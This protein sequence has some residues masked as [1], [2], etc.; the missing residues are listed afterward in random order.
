[1]KSLFKKLIEVLCKTWVWSLLLVFLLA[2][3]IWSFGPL[4]AVSDNRFWEGT[5]A[6]LITISVLFLVWGL[7]M[8]FTNWR[9][10]LIK[11]QAEES[12]TGKECLRKSVVMEKERLELA[13]RFTDAQRVLKDSALFGE[14]GARGRKELPWYVLIGPQGSGKTSLLDF[15]GLDFPLDRPAR[16]LTRDTSSTGSC[17]WYFTHQAILLDTSGRYFDQ[18]D[19]Q[20]DG[21]AWMT[22]LGL[23][24]G[25]LRTQPLSGVLVTL[26]VDILLD[27]LDKRLEKVAGDVRVRLDEIFRRLHVDVPVYLVLTKADSIAG[28]DDFFDQLSREESEQV[29]GTTF[30][31][32]QRGTDVDV[33]SQAFE[34]LLQ[35]LGS[36]VITRIHQE[37]DSQRRGRMLEFPNQLGGIGRRLNIF[38]ELAFSGNRYQRASQLR[39]FYLTRAPHVMQ[40]GGQQP[41][42]E[43][44]AGLPVQHGGRARFIHDLLRHVIFPESDLA[45]LGKE[46]RKKIQW[47]QKGMY[48]AAL[49]FLAVS[50]ALW[51]T[52][53]NANHDRLEKLRTLGEQWTRQTSSLTAEDDLL[54]ILASLNTLYEAARV[55][56]DS[57]EVALY[58]RSGLYQGQPANEVLMRAYHAGLQT[59]L[60]PRMVSM[61]EARILDSLRDREQLLS[62]LRAYLM[63]IQREHRLPSALE[64]WATADWSIR[65]AGHAQAQRE[66]N[67]H[68]KRLLALPFVY[69]ANDALVAQAR[70]VLRN[71]SLATVVYRVLREK[72]RVLPDYSLAHHTGPQ[73]AVLAGADYRI[74]GLYTRQGYER[75]FVTHGTGLVTEIM[76]DNWVLGEGAPFSVTQLRALMVELEKLY[77]R[78]YADHWAEAIGRVSLHPFEG[79]AQGAVQMA[80]LA[81]AH[82]PLLR[83]LTE[84]RDNTR[85]PMLADSL[86]AAKTQVGKTVSTPAVL[87]QAVALG[88]QLQ[89]SAASSL[90]ETAKKSLQ[91]RFD[92]LHRLLDEESGPS[93]DLMAAL[94]A[95]NELQMQMAALARSG[96]PDL[97]A[98]E[99]AKG[100]MSGQRDAL[101]NLRSAATVLPQPVGGWFDKLAEDTWSFVL[102]QSHH[103]LNQRYKAE[104]YS[105]YEQ[106]LDKRYPFHA[107][108]S[109][110]VALEDFRE[111]FGPQGIAERFFDNYLRPFV[112]GSP[113]NLRLRTLDGYSLPMSRAYLHQMAGVHDIRK[114]FFSTHTPEPQVQFTLEP[115][116]LDPGVRRAEFR[117]GDQSLE[118]RHGPIVPMGFKWPAGIDNGRAS[119][120]MDGRLG[121]PLGIEKNNGPWSLFRLFDLMQTEPLQGRDVLLLKADVGGMRAHYLLSSLRAPN[122]FDMT[123][124]R[125]FRMPAQL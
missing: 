124:L 94:N 9:G 17:D 10:S 43:T 104:L 8:V 37:R 16:K 25:R 116:T 76:R 51:A 73:E 96:Q 53:F 107:H 91:R 24:Q 19:P 55:F 52:G 69:P 23:L 13:S 115:Y 42:P 120:V 93:A 80:G 61:F 123:A 21:G 119:L 75:Y 74:P 2:A 60:L 36:Q 14:L 40:Q 99:M 45:M 28:F 101:N 32:G 108:S 83:L 12:E 109:S 7:G 62:S 50:G 15:S 105:F 84:V 85:F 89:Q 72:A 92:A 38:A 70:Q 68:F 90:P 112:S 98:Y 113:G 63:L 20:V 121:R 57:D 26:P 87:D 22:L 65:Y 6:R 34:T 79:P 3:S 27:G 58:E 71:E 54:T 59:Q 100:R 41:E 44:G 102:Y 47:R 110:D 39:G 5:S 81:A 106:S 46:A 67:Q 103:Y 88:E 11:R 18:P 49:L 117:L 125:G 66:L 1:M 48:C 31:K 4:L 95:V 97:A 111:F 118:Y 78:D 56:P 29:L 33:I 82:S 30:K 64:T 77:F 114:S 86:D 35:R 122:P